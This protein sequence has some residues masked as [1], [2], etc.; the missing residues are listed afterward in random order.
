MILLNLSEDAFLI[1]VLSSISPCDVSPYLIRSIS[2]AFQRFYDRVMWSIV[3]KGFLQGKT[4]PS[5]M[6]PQRMCNL[7]LQGPLQDLISGQTLQSFRQSS[8]CCLRLKGSFLSLP[9]KGVAQHNNFSRFASS[10]KH[11][12]S[13][14][15]RVGRAEESQ[16]A[17]SFRMQQAGDTPHRHML[18]HHPLADV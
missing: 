11:S 17:E 6:T 9:E 3:A 7:G 15:D 14:S 16:H 8:L 18:Y 1:A 13:A 5:D 2:K 12:P 4:L 10:R